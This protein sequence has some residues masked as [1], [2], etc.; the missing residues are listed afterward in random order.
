M[1]LLEFIGVGYLT[2][3]AISM[4][5]RWR[6]PKIAIEFGKVVE[7]HLHTAL[8]EAFESGMLTAADMVTMS[9]EE[10]LAGKIRKVV[11]YTKVA[12]DN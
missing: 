10:E 1:T 5:N 11:E 3:T 12:N 2:V 4:I 9:G 6:K 7:E 8:R